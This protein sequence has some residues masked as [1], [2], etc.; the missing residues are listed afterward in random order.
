V[1][2]DWKSAATGTKMKTQDEL[3]S[4][5]DN[6]ASNESP[7][8]MNAVYVHALIIDKLIQIENRLHR[9]EELQNK[10]EPATT[11]R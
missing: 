2:R 3:R 11:E 8:G 5:I 1:N 7:V 6:I 10:S 4:I 9:L